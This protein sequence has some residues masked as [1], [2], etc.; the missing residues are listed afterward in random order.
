M[1]KVSD[2]Y[3]DN[4]EWLKGEDMAD[5]EV[6]VRIASFEETK[7]D[8]DPLPKISLRFEGA[9]KGLTL[10]KTNARK[11]AAAYGDYCENWVGKEIIVYGDKVEYQGR[12]V[13]GIRVRI[14]PAQ[15]QDDD[16]LPF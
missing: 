3:S 14:P 12:L 2:Y 7:F 6:K 10:N 4:S 13:D 16:D 9:K 1:A 11:I 8:N 15:Q 5:K